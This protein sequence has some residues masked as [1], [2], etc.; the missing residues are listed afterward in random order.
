MLY[1][2]DPVALQS[3]L[4]KDSHLYEEA[5]DFQVYVMCR[6]PLEIFLI[7]STASTM[8]LLFGPNIL[9]CSGETHRRQ[10]RMLNPVFSSGNLRSVTNVFWDVSKTVSRLLYHH[11]HPWPELINVSSCK[12]QLN[13][14]FKVFQR[15]WIC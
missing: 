7:L 9:S 3:I 13:L 12:I 4:V 15:S 5:H 2:T 1:V 6:L 10:R 8:Q 11:R 14:S